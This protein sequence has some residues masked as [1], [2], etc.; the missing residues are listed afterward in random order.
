MCCK[1]NGR[2]LRFV[3]GRIT[4]HARVVTC[5]VHHTLAMCTSLYILGDSSPCVQTISRIKVSGNPYPP[6]ASQ[7]KGDQMLC[8]IA[9]VFLDLKMAEW[10]AS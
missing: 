7:A 9:A 8:C 6:Y 4:R 5:T 10:K 3:T 1:M 2:P